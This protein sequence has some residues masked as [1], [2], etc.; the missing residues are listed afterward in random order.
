MF[1]IFSKILLTQQLIFINQKKSVMKKNVLPIDLRNFL[2]LLLIG[3]FFFLVSSCSD[4]DTA[5]E[6]IAPTNVYKCTTCKTSSEALAVNDNSSKGIYIGFTESG[7]L[8]IDIDNKNI[9]EMKASLLK[10]N[11]TRTLTFLESYSDSERYYAIFADNNGTPISLA[12]D[13]MLNGNNPQI[14][15][16]ND[17]VFKTANDVNTIYKE[18]S[19]EMIEVFE[20]Y[21]IGVSH[22]TQLNEK[23]ADELIVISRSKAYWS[24]MRSYSY[25]GFQET[26]NALSKNSGKIIGNNLIDNDNNQNGTLNSDLI[27]GKV[28]SESNDLSIELKRVI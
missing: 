25:V 17:L 12:F 6:V 18:R 14:T 7:I 5:S 28:Y 16:R 13:V 19:N 20:G 8:S 10:N 23:L 3:S 1:K 26:I 11:I 4:N 22:A 27:S 15:L 9:G 2:M 21:L 24:E